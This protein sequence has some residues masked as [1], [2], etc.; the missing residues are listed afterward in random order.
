[1][2]VALDRLHGEIARLFQDVG[3]SPGH[4]D[5]VA[6][7][8]LDAEVEGQSGHGLGRVRMYRRQVE[9]GGLNP[10]PELRW[11]WPRE[12][13]GILH[14]DR[15]LGP[16]AGLRA[17]EELMAATSHQGQASVAVRN[18]GHMGALSA[19]VGRLADHGFLGLAM[20][21]TPSAMAPWG[22]AGQVLGTN[23]IAFAAPIDEGHSPLVIDL[24]LSVA[25]RGK[26]FQAQ[27]QQTDIPEGW[28]I[29]AEGQPTTDP[30][31]ALAG[32]LL[33]IGEAKGYALALMV[34]VLAGVMAGNALSA[35]LPKPWEDPSSPSTPGLWLMALDPG[36]TDHGGYAARMRQLVDEIERHGGRLPGARRREMRQQAERDGIELSP[37]RRHELAALGM[38]LDEGP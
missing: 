17:L 36:A 11:A 15:A 22:G 19:Y 2:R 23:P 27:S 1:M 34:E 5:D 25:A 18:A 38:A 21:N 12:A 26:I 14:A 30:D 3:L 33:P 24:S 29:D 28:A 37:Q 13:M 20:A 10:E 31:R 8:L 16:V 4:A 9:A 32:S 7:V 6:T 35:E